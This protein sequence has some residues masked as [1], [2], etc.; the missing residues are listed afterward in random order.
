M[1][2]PK[3]VGLEQEYALKMRSG[4]EKDAFHTSCL[5]VNAY[6]RL[7]EEGS[8]SLFNVGTSSSTFHHQYKNGGSGSLIEDGPQLAEKYNFPMPTT[9]QKRSPRRPTG[10]FAA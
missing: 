3:V 9:A 6:A 7:K 2:V 10:M 5:L 1:S 4:G 8:T